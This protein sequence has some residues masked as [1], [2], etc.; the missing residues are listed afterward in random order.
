MIFLFWSRDAL[1]KISIFLMNFQSLDILSTKTLI[2]LH[3]LLL[4][5]LLQWFLSKFFVPLIPLFLPRKRSPILLSLKLIRDVDGFYLCQVECDIGKDLNILYSEGSNW[6][7][8][9]WEDGDIYFVEAENFIL[10]LDFELGVRPFL[11]TRCSS[12]HG[13]LPL[14][15]WWGCRCLAL[16]F[17]FHFI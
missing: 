12:S 11:H 15:M 16:W 5:R 4:P 2:L 6:L 8:S 3:I 13:I 17:I 10:V 9:I 1:S 14:R 7:I